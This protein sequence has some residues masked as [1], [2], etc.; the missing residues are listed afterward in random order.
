ML[1]ES[2]RWV[3]VPPAGVVA[4][5]DERLLVHTSGPH[6]RGMSRVWRSR[7]DREG[8]EGLI[9]RTIEDACAAGA[10]RLVWHTGDGV[11]PAFLDEL[12]P[13]HGFE[14]TED[15]EVLAFELGAGPE[16]ELPRLRVPTDVDTRPVM[17][18]ADLRRANVVDA[19]V[20]DGPAWGELEMRAYLE[21]LSKLEGR[22]RRGYPIPDGRIQYEA[23]LVLRYLAFVREKGDE[24]T[25]AVA[26]AV[27][28]A[29]AEV[30]GGTV[31]LWG[32]GTLAEQ[33]GRGAYSALVT[34]RCRHAHALGATLALTKANAV[35]SAP[36]LRR[37]G[38][39]LVARERRY[40]TEIF[41]RTRPRSRRP[42]RDPG[43]V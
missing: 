16:P 7:T 31:R 1:R 24:E 22:V 17:D 23:P 34:K 25:G 35:S 6:A 14:R 13:R 15:L 30:T 11:S 27:A 41:A 4:E 29:G 38:F 2:A 40:A 43:P 21:G 33:R 8:A 19:S 42:D 18:E 10:A 32:A 5:D 26:T 9:L 28:T 12:L 3:H 36:I 20:S 37:A 39:R